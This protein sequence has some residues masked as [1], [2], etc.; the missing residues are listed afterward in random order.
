VS[1]TV[2]HFFL[3]A[4]LGIHAFLFVATVVVVGFIAVVCGSH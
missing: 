4:F 2:M 3:Y 1:L